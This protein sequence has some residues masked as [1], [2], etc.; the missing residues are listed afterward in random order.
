MTVYNYLTIG[1]MGWCAKLV[2]YLC[3]GAVPLA[4][5]LVYFHLECVKEKEVTMRNKFN[6]EYHPELT[7]CTV[8]LP[9]M[10]SD[11]FTLKFG[12]CALSRS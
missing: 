12:D 5:V 8:E 9:F 2:K 6:D 3:Y 10:V 1:I 4:A 11:V 7:D